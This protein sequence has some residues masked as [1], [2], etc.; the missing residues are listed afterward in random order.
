MGAPMAREMVEALHP[1]GKSATRV[2]RED[3]EAYRR[4][5][6]R[7]IPRTKGGVAFMHLPELVEEIL[8]EE[9]RARTRAMWWVTTVKLDL[10]ARGLIERVPGATPQFVRRVR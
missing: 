6:L 7:V 9:V 4:A 5:L 1:L 8:T 10:E 2:N 3:Y